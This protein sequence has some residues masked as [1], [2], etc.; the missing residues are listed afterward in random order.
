MTS[1]S[2]W[3]HVVFNLFQPYDTD[4]ANRGMAVVQTASDALFLSD[5]GG[6]IDS[7]DTGI[8]P[9]FRTGTFPT[10]WPSDRREAVLE[11]AKVV[12]MA[13][14]RAYVRHL[15]S[16]GVLTD[17]A[18]KDFGLAPHT[19]PG[20]EDLVAYVAE[21]WDRITVLAQDL[22]DARGGM[23]TGPWIPPPTTS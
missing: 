18:W 21:Q 7:I 23:L 20:H 16:T 17:G 19:E 12:T 14:A 13:A 15:K 4:S 9:P 3:L 22:I 1:P 11:Q 8:L 6:T 2:P 5:Q 10:E